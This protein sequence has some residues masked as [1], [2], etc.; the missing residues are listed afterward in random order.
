V[1]S[2]RRARTLSVD[3]FLR[4]IGLPTAGAVRVSFGLASTVGDVERFVEFAEATY[5]DRR[6]DTTGLPPRDR[7]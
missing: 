5:R 3:V 1:R 6:P 4:L 2:V 7:C